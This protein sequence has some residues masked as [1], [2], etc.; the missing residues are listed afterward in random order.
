MRPGFARLAKLLHEVGALGRL[1]ARSHTQLVEQ[2]VAY[3]DVETLY[4]AP[5]HRRRQARELEV[6]G[7]RGGAPVGG[8]RVRAGQRAP[9]A[10]VVLAAVVA[11]RHLR[12][13]DGVD[14]RPQPAQQVDVAQHVAVLIRGALR[15]DARLTLVTGAALERVA[16]DELAARRQPRGAG[17]VEVD[18]R[19][20]RV[21]HGLRDAVAQAQ[22]MHRRR[23]WALGPRTQGGA[24]P[25]PRVAQ[26]PDPGWRPRTQ[27]GGADPGPRVAARSFALVPS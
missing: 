20:P 23:P 15:R 2:L 10:E 13:S 21:V 6:G 27:G 12:S 9:L 16:H 4:A 5:S 11:L 14:R 1:G 19:R 24:N 7:I 17:G 8:Q 26:T 25:G 22:L 3:V 18:P